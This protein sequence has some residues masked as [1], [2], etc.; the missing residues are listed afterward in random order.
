MQS[1]DTKCPN[2]TRITHLAVPITRKQTPVAARSHTI[3]CSSP[4]YYPLLIAIPDFGENRLIRGPTD[5]HAFEAGAFKMLFLGLDRGRFAWK[6]PPLGSRV[7]SVF[8]VIDTESAVS[9]MLR[10]DDNSRAHKSRTR[11][12]CNG[13]PSRDSDVDANRRRR[14]H[15]P[16]IR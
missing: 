6:C 7:S 14:Q 10:T 1:R 8:G 16:D 5:K 3:H 4:S 15:F 9:G 13:L 2:M 12:V 11:G